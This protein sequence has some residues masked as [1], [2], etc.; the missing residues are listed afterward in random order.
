MRILVTGGAGFIGSHAAVSLVRGGHEVMVL[1]DLS[2]G[3][4]E[5]LDEV[6]V[7]WAVADIRDREAVARALVG[8]EGVLHLAGFVSVPGSIAEPVRSAEVNVI[9]TAL[10]LEESRRAGVR[11]VVLAS[12]AAVYGDGVRVPTAET[13][14]PRPRSPYG[15]QKLAAEHLL[16]VAAETGGPDT[17][18][19][20]FFNVYGTR[21]SP[22]SDYAAVIPLLGERCAR[23]L[24]PRIF[25]DGGQTRDF[26]LVADVVEG[27]RRALSS[28]QDFGGEVFNLA[29]G[30]ASA[31]SMLAAEIAAQHGVSVAPERLP[32][33]A[34]DIRHSVADLT[35]LRAAFGWSPPTPLAEGLRIAL[36]RAAPPRPGARE[37]V[38]ARAE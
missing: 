23:G 24:A 38:V 18:S 20:R 29:R 25:G 1:D 28:E 2:S 8:V 14:S 31:I 19:F 6:P 16:R 13:E 27:L 26:V 35:K 22:D 5:N 32:P 10:L 17:V 9:G 7:E 36:A 33:R 30:E 21:Q 4:R 11:R 34:G 12:S 15:A 37:T 3:R